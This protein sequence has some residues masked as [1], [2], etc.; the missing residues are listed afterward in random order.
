SGWSYA[1]W[2]K[3]FYK[4]VAPRDWL[5]FYAKHFGAV[6]INSSFYR[7]QTPETF[8]KWNKKTPEDFAFAVKG[9]RFITHVKRLK[10]PAE[11]VKRQR[12]SVLELGEKLSAVLWQLPKNFVKNQD[13]L[14]AF[15]KALNTHFKD[16]PQVMEFRHTSWFDQETEDLLRKFSLANCISNAADW[17]CWDAV[18]SNTAYVRLHGAERTYHS[19]YGEAGLKE[20]AERIKAWLAEKRTVHVY[21]DNTGQGAAVRDALRLKEILEETPPKA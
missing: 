17:P 20:Y 6:E 4:G 13:R 2:K 11:P 1:V 10:D 15:A 5:G 8:R 3:N 21:F 12:Q 16:A 18:T 14:L 7:E 19:E 9:H